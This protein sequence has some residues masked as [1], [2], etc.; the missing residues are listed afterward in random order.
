M[1]SAIRKTWCIFVWCFVVCFL[2]PLAEIRKGVPRFQS[3]MLRIASDAPS[4]WNDAS[5]LEDL[6]WNISI[7]STLHLGSVALKLYGDSLLCNNP[8]GDC[9]WVGTYQIS[10][11]LHFA[12]LLVLH[13]LI[14][15]PFLFFFQGKVEDRHHTPD[16]CSSGPQESG[17]MLSKA[18]DMGFLRTY[19]KL[20]KWLNDVKGVMGLSKMCWVHIH[21]WGPVRTDPFFCALSLGMPLSSSF[22]V[23]LLTGE[24][25]W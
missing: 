4:V 13:L 9:Y 15:W 12:Y 25:S 7:G 6:W 11:E 22:M 23:D 17:P 18:H 20:N 10:T 21:F 2:K 1:F 19:G 8:E 16:T 24:R 5:H 14:H 3:T